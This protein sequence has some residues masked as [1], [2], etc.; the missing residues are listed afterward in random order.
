MSKVERENHRSSQLSP[1]ARKPLCTYM[2]FLFVCLFLNKNGVVGVPLWS[3]LT[4]LCGSLSRHYAWTYISSWGGCRVG[5][6]SGAGCLLSLSTVLD[7]RALWDTRETEEE[8]TE[9]LDVNSTSTSMKTP[10]APSLGHELGEASGR[11]LLSHSL[12]YF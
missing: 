10:T 11:N 4:H 12:S 2:S 7:D 3:Y 1:F 5:P 6:P 8:G 9:S